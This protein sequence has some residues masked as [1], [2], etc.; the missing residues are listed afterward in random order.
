MTLA[1]MRQ[2]ILDDAE[3]KA[4]ETAKEADAEREKILDDARAQKKTLLE[5]AKADAEK[6]ADLFLMEHNAEIEIDRHNALLTARE[7]AI[8]ANRGAAA[9]AILSEVLKN[10]AK[11]V[12]KAAANFRSVAG[13]KTGMV[14]RAEKKYQKLLKGIGFTIWDAEKGIRIE[15]ADGTAKMDVSPE[16]ILEENMDD[17]KAII[18]NI[19]FEENRTAGKTVGVRKTAYSKRVNRQKARLKRKKGR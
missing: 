13:E 12:Q 2:E 18:A 9:R 7:E 6:W 19:L 10:Y 4:E 5:R 1:Q 15:T 14:I 16:R 17:I 8:I 3:K 11:V